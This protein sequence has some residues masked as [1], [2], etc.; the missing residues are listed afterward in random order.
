[1]NKSLKNVLEFRRQSLELQDS[2]FSKDTITLDRLDE[3]IENNDATIDELRRI[4]RLFQIN[5]FQLVTTYQLDFYPPFSEKTLE[6]AIDNGNTNFIIDCLENNFIVRHDNNLYFANFN[7]KINKP[8]SKSLINKL[9]NYLM[10]NGYYYLVNTHYFEGCGFKVENTADLDKYGEK[11]KM[12]FLFG[13][14]YLQK[15]NKIYEYQ[16]FIPS[17]LNDFIRKLSHQDRCEV[18]NL[19]F[20]VLRKHK[21]ILVHYTDG[22]NYKLKYV[23]DT[24]FVETKDCCM[25]ISSYKLDDFEGCE[26]IQSKIKTIEKEIEQFLSQYKEGE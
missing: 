8:L 23:A 7:G 10:T 17:Y 20:Y 11:A 14:T 9:F 24:L 1:M 15:E 5:F 25:S 13:S 21:N 12:F 19:Y 22:V 18:L 3:I 2:D 26:D 6:K 16:L 4:A